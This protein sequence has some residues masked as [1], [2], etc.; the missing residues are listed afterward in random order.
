MAQ[1]T[2]WVVGD[3]KRDAFAEAVAWMR[4]AARCVFFDSM[5]AP[6]SPRPDENSGP[7]AIVIVESR[8]GQFSR[9]EVERL[10]AA[11]PL[12]R[13]VALLGTWCEGE[14]RSG[15]PWPGVVRVPASSWRWRLPRELGLA[16]G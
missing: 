14:E 2:V 11:E 10:H 7:G 13:L 1:Q 8:P 3:W 5:E 6:F 4:S 9:R 16:S 15:R 12:A